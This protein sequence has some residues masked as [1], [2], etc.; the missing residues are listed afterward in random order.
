[1]KSGFVSII[2]RPNVGKSTLINTIINRK[3]AITSN[4]S[5]TTRNIIQG[6]YNDSDTQIVFVDTPGIHKPINRL[7]KVLNKEALALT[8]DVDL[9]LFVV[10]VASGI[11]KGDM[12]ILESLKNND[13]PVILVLNKIDEIT[14]EK[15]FKTIDEFK[16]IYPFVEVVPTSGLKN[17]NVDHLINVI[18]KYLHDEVK[19]F[20]DEYYTSSS[21]KFMASEIVREKLLQVTE[22]EIPHSITCITT[23][24]EEKKDIVNISVDIIVDRDNIKRIIIGKNGSRLKTVGTL[25]RAEIESEL[26]GKKVYL[27]LFVKT[28]KNWKDKEKYL[29]ELGFINNE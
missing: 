20:P 4:V 12:F 10:D 14:T 18:K 24:F 28:I 25:A 7:G 8:K 22:D 16:D 17:D 27:E 29:V 13:V 23:L 26:V 3:V 19:Y 2:G 1:M 15:L 9:I 21:M 6:I 11:G 5:G